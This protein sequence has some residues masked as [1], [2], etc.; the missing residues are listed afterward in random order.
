[1]KTVFGINTAAHLR[2]ASEP[3]ASAG[4]RKDRQRLSDLISVVTMPPSIN[5]F[6]ECHRKGCIF[7]LRWSERGFL[8]G[9]RCATCQRTSPLRNCLAMPVALFRQFIRP[10]SDTSRRDRTA[11]RTADL[12]PYD[13]LTATEFYRSGSAPGLIDF[14]SAVLDRRQQAWPCSGLPHERRRLRR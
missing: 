4:I 3:V 5:R 7:R 1:M 12:M 11:D 6:G 13:E 14:V 9:R 2:P 10:Q 8:Q